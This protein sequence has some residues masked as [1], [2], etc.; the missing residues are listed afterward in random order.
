MSNILTTQLDFVGVKD[1]W[2]LTQS[3]ESQTSR[4]YRYLDL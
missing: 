1:V 2:E 3:M 4:L